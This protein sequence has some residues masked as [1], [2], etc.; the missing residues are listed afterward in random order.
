MTVLSELGSCCD[1]FKLY[2]YPSMPSLNTSHYMLCYTNSLWGFSLGRSH[3][4]TRHQL[5]HVK[6]LIGG[7]VWLLNCVETFDELSVGFDD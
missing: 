2:L 6:K 3:K 5:I 1:F 4:G 7:R